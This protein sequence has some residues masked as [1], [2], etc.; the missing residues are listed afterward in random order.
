[1]LVPYIFARNIDRKRPSHKRV[2]RRAGD[3][4]SVISYT[5]SG[6]RDRCPHVRHQLADFLPGRPVSLAPPAPPPGRHPPRSPPPPPG[7]ALPTGRDDRYGD[8]LEKSGVKLLNGSMSTNCCARHHMRPPDWVPQ[9]A[10]A[11][12]R[13]IARGDS[14]GCGSAGRARETE[15]C[16][17]GGAWP[18]VMVIT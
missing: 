6:T 9:G 12:E 1:M 11:R 10:R 16:T 5:S 13:E 17:H 2:W 8:R 18:H 3:H 4:R 7:A 15:S 14:E